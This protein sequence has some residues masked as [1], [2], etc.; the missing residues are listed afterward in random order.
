MLPVTHCQLWTH[1]RL[2]A[3]FLTGVVRNS[4]LG[5]LHSGVWFV[6]PHTSACLQIRDIGSGNFG[7]VK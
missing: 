1:L 4:L 3:L 2:V 7:V 6:D 5:A